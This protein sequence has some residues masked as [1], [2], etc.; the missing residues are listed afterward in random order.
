MGHLHNTVS[1]VL[2]QMQLS[3]LDKVCVMFVYSVYS[4]PMFQM[5][6]GYDECHIG[7]CPDKVLLLI[8]GYIPHKSLISICSR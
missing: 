4:P 7:R 3:I 6:A 1:S 8:L 2:I 5:T